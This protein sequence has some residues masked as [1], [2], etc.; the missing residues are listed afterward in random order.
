MRYAISG[1]SRGIGLEFVRQ[2]LARGDTVEAGARVPWEARQLTALARDAGERL[3]IHALDVKNTASVRAFAASIG[4]APIDVLINNAGVSGKWNP[5]GELDFED[6]AHV[7]E[8]NAIGPMRMASALLPLVLKG[9][10]RKIVHLTT[11]MGSL[12]ENTP[13]GVYGFA[14]GAY[15]Y[16][17][18]KAALNQGMR[19]MAV[20]FREKG[21]ITALL[22]PGWVQTDMGSKMAPTRVD[23]CVQGLLRVI[24]ELTLARSGCFFDFQGKE[25]LW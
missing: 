19:T 5:L 21:L 3:R 1:A 18:S 20:D 15:A 6:M 9:N 2:L 13:A 16:R 24:D 12:T 7:M 17:M 25:M 10:T 14:G 22:N 8:T 11:R 23:E 4:E